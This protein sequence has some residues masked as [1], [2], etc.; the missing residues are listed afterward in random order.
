MN[1]QLCRPQLE[2]NLYFERLLSVRAA[3]NDFGIGLTNDT[4][5]MIFPQ[6]SWH[7]LKLLTPWDLRF[8]YQ[9]LT[10]Y[11]VTIHNNQERIMSVDYTPHCI[12]SAVGLILQNAFKP[13][14]AQIH[15]VTSAGRL[16]FVFL[17]F[18][19]THFFMYL[20]I[21]S[22]CM[23]WATPYSSSGDR[24]VLIHHLVWL[25]CVSDCLICRSGIPSSHLHRL[26]IPDDV[27]IRFDLLMMNTVMLET[28]REMK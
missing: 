11:D 25:V 21:S 22:L 18:N 28:C 17:L 1:K 15:A 3:Q 20:F 14:G 23:F 5:K 10:A 8:M 16:H 2:T 7:T 4:I 24:I 19:L 6:C 13:S 27:L 26:I 12:R 9:S